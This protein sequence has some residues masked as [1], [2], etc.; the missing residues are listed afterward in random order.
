MALRHGVRFPSRTG[1]PAAVDRLSRCRQTALDRSCYDLLASEARL[2]S[3]I[4]I[5]KGDVPARHW[6]R[7]GRDVT[8]VGHGAALISWSGSMFEYLMPSL[9]MR[10]PRG[11]LLEQTNRLVVRAADQATADGLGVPW[12]I[13]ESAYNARDME[14]TYQYS[15]FGVPGLGLQARPEREPVIAP[16]A[17]ALAAMVDPPPRHANFARLAAMGGRGRYG[18]YEALD[19]TPSRLPEGQAVAIVRAYMAHHQGMTVVAIANALLDGVMRTRFHAEPMIQATELL[20]QERT[21]RDVAV[22]HPRAEEVGASATAT[23]S[24]RPRCAACTSPHAGQPVHAPAV[25]RPLRGDAD[26]RRLGLQPLARHRGHAL[27]RGRDARRLGQ[28]RLPA[29]CPTAARSGR[30]ATSRRGD[31][32]RQLRR[33]VRRGSRRVRPARRQRSRPPSTSSS[34]RR[35]TP[36]SGACRS[37]IAAAERASIELTSYAEIVLAPPAADAAHPAFSKLFVADRVPCRVRRPPGD[38]AP[39]ARRTSRAL[40]RPSRGR[41]GRGDRRRRDRDRPRPLPRPRQRRRR[42]RRGDRRPAAVRTPSA[43]CSIRSSRCAAGCAFAP[44]GTARVAF[45]TVVASSR[46][47]LLDADRQASRRQRLRARRDACLDAGAGAVAPS[48][49]RVRRGDLF[50]RLAGHVLYADP[51]LRPSS[52][53][54]LRGAGRAAGAVGARHLRRPADR[55]A[56]ASTRSRTSTSS[57]SCCAPTNTGGMKGLAVDLVILNERRASYVAGPADRHRD[58]GAQPA[59]RGRTSAEERRRGGVFVLRGRPDVRRDA[60]PAVAVAR[61]GAAR[62]ARRPGRAARP[63][64]AT[65]RGVPPPRRRSRRAGRRTRSPPPVAALVAASSSMASAASRRMAASM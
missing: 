23:T 37:P 11:S 41:R 35:T 25:Q 17:T 60:R 51:S 15:N 19:F 26:R 57:A 56:C 13:S 8:P 10:A 12:G 44:G 36:R 32:A 54:I 2:A 43:P 46:E 63:R 20:L 16:Y 42:R 4:A 22:A 18:F 24:S 1:A 30:P 52:D 33:H 39:R 29:R 5:A 38:A 45:W 6:F 53:A 50:Q 48:R 21:P 62:P 61:V 55:A 7:L 9:V 34:R 28:L 58:A 65:P 31:A 49:H 14:L 47:A 59:S 27:A 3:F 64:C 40:G